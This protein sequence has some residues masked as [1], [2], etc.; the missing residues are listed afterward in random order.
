MAANRP[1]PGPLF[2]ASPRPSGPFVRRDRDWQ[3]VVVAVSLVAM[4]VFEMFHS[5]PCDLDF[6]TCTGSRFAAQIAINAIWATVMG[7]VTGVALAAIMNL[8]VESLDARRSEKSAAPLVRTL[9]LLA[10]AVLVFVIVLVR[11]DFVAS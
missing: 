1:E 6:D 5:P 10:A 8:A 9:L 11:F 7:V 2:S 4:F 3:I